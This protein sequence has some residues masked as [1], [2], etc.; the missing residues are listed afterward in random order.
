MSGQQPPP[1]PGP[2]GQQ[3]PPV[4]PPPYPGPPAQPHPGYYPPYSGQQPGTGPQFP[5]YQP[6]GPTRKEPPDSTARLIGWLQASVGL[7]LVVAPFLTWWTIDAEG[8]SASFRGLGFETVEGVEV[9]VGDGLLTLL[10]A[11]VVIAFAVARGLGA[12]SLTAGI[13]GITLGALI[14]LIAIADSVTDEPVRLEGPNGDEIPLTSVDWSIG[15]G[16]WL[17][18]VAGVGMIALSVVGVV[19]RR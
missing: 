12:L 9:K 8:S 15:L 16:L 10:L 3:P 1:Y 17:T 5:G 2:Y 19:K 18:L 4:Q 11:A 7:V 6:Y 14:T 13:L